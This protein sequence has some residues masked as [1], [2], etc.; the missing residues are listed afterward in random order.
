MQSWRAY[1]QTEKAE[2]KTHCGVKYQGHNDWQACGNSSYSSTKCLKFI[3]KSK[4]FCKTVVV[5]IL[6]AFYH[7]E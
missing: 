3:A 2:D 1:L 4:R 5:K 6:Y 7:E